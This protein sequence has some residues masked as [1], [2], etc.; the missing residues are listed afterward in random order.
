MEGADESANNAI[1]RLILTGL[2]AYVFTKDLG[3]AMRV[4]EVGRVC[5]AGPPL[6]H[7]PQPSPLLL[8]LL[9]TYQALEYGMVGINNPLISTAVAPFGGFKESG[10]GREGSRHGIDEYTEI[11]YWNI[12]F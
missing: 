11:K 7:Y 1:T 2:V 8:L 5:S 3:R 10:I 12:R 4:G 6:L 9:L